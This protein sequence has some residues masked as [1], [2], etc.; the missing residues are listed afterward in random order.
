MGVAIA[1]A[2]DNGYGEV[3]GSR[4]GERRRAQANS[5]PAFAYEGLSCQQRNWIWNLNA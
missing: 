2:V 3:F 5:M 4:D 1:Y